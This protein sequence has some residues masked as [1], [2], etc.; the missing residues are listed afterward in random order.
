MI[1]EIKLFSVIGKGLDV[2][3]LNTANT[4][5]DISTAPTGIYYLLV[6]L[7]NGQL[8]SKKILKSD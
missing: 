6:R 2:V 1:K 4:E 7:D 5:V 8:L 3:G